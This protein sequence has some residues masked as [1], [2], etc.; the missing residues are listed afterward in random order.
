MVLRIHEDL[1]PV[2]VAVLPIFRKEPMLGIARD[3]HARLLEH[4]LPVELDETQAVGRRY[5]R[6]DEIGTPLCIT[7]DHR[8][9]EDGTVTL[10]CRD[11]MAQIRMPGAEV[12]RRAAE[13]TLRRSA[14]NDHFAAAAAA[15]AEEH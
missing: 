14:L 10:R 1:A 5:R 3:I 12:V 4:C 15:L 6:Q 2:K 9:G 8:S 13:G 11:S 7:V